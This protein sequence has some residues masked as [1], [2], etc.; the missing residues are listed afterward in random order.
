MHPAGQLFW[1]PSRAPWQP[2]C[3]ILFE[4][5]QAISK[6]IVDASHKQQ[7]Q[8]EPQSSQCLHALGKTCRRLWL[9]TADC[10]LKHLILVTLQNVVILSA[11]YAPSAIAPDCPWCLQDIAPDCFGKGAGISCASTAGCLGH[12]TQLQV[13]LSFK[14]MSVL[15][16][17]SP[18]GWQC[19]MAVIANRHDNIHSLPEQ[20]CIKVLDV[21]PLMRFKATHDHLRVAIACLQRH[22]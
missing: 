1:L 8:Q 22:Q 10:L 14:N 20:T 11:D 12:A 13:S 2:S 21:I 6:L 17:H 3:C 15:C 18:Q 19:L 5:S 4:Y 7:E 9:V 16:C